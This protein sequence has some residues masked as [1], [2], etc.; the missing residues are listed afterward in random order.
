MNLKLNVILDVQAKK[1]NCSTKEIAFEWK[2]DLQSW[3][4]SNSTI[5]IANMNLISVIT[6]PANTLHTSS[7]L[8]STQ[9]TSTTIQINME[10]L[11]P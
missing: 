7:I 3:Y 5:I 4:K 2:I 6:F 10:K 8:L 11:S 1:Q 9:K